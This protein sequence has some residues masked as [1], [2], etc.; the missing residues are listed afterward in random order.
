MVFIEFTNP[1]LAV[2]GI[3]ILS[4]YIIIYIAYIYVIKGKFDISE[5]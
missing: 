5:V 2:K 4:I 1:N 3:K